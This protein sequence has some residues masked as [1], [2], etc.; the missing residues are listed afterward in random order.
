MPVYSE[1]MNDGQSP[2]HPL[3]RKLYEKLIKYQPIEQILRPKR[4]AVPGGYC[5]LLEAASLAQEGIIIGKQIA[6][7]HR[8]GQPEPYS[9]RHSVVT[10]CTMVIR[11]GMPIYFVGEDFIR[12]VAATS[13]PEDLRIEE[14][15][16]PRQAMILAFPTRFMREYV[17]QDISYV[18]VANVKKG[19]YSLSPMVSGV[20]TMC[21]NKDKFCLHTMIWN[22][23]QNQTENGL[24]AWEQDNILAQAAGRYDYT[25]MC[26]SDEAAIKY[27]RETNNMLG[28]LVLKL[29]LILSMRKDFIVEGQI[30]RPE[31]RDRKGR[32]EQTELWEPS[33]IGWNYR[34]LESRVKEGE[35]GERGVREYTPHQ[36]WI[37]RKGHITHQFVGSREVDLVSTKSLPKL[38]TGE[39]DWSQVPKETQNRFW[40]QHERKWIEPI[41]F[42][43]AESHAKA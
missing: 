20:P 41:W 30:Q 35:E 36:G 26:G 4:I 31:K 22:T 38:S 17:G 3:L 37:K 8:R 29:L 9:L 13:L 25:D 19:E 1:R 27:K 10:T 18:S 15:L 34:L 16:W 23:A 12:A 5:A 39:I 28:N 40:A 2:L 43:P 11:E 21:P 32:V 42:N 7:S 24:V 33:T 14:L 6:D